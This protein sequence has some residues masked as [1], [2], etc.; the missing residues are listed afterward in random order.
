M[1]RYRVCV[2]Q[3]VEETAVLEITA[4]TPDI[5]A[6]MAGK[7][8]RAGDIDNWQ[9]GDDITNQAVYAVLDENRDIVWER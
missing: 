9:A 3:Y 2:Q 6:E 1:P 7:R 4:A 5:A 8:L